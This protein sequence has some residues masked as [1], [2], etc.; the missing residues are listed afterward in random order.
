LIHLLV[1]FSVPNSKTS[2]T[3]T[4]QITSHSKRTII[5]LCI[6]NFTIGQLLVL[7]IETSS[8]TSYHNNFFMQFPP[9]SDFSITTLNHGFLASSQTHVNNSSYEVN[10]LLVVYCIRWTIKWL[11]IVGGT[12]SLTLSEGLSTIGG[13]T[14]TLTLSKVLSTGGEETSTFK[15]SRSS[16]ICNMR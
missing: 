1:V 13:G 3:R 4:E 11:T 8:F 15:L 12:S 6:N 9:L 2:I 5:F 16:E 10:F 14:S 7:D